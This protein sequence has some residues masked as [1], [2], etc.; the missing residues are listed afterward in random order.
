M[1][2]ILS[3]KSEHVVDRAHAEEKEQFS[4]QVFPKF[5]IRSCCY[6]GFYNPAMELPYL[7]LRKN[8]R[9]TCKSYILHSGLFQYDRK[10]IHRQ[11]K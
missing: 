7:A 3:G 11:R 8:I 10:Q 4:C 2:T 5:A 1:M 9:W 6:T